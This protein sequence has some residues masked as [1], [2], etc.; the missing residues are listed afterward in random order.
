MLLQK[1]FLRKVFF[2]LLP[3]GAF[4]QWL[5]YPAP[6]IPRTADGKPNLNAPTPRTADGKP[7]LSGVWEGPGPGSYD[8][9][10]TRDLKPSDIQPWAEAVYHERVLNMGKDAPRAACLP[11]PFV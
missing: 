9:T 7:D 3:I 6:G 2:L 8:R 11:D 4:A 1:V 10:I 5:N